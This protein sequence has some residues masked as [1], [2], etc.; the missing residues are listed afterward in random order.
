MVKEMHE[1]FESMNQA[2][3]EADIQNNIAYELRQEALRAQFQATSAAESATLIAEMMT[4]CTDPQ[5]FRQLAATSRQ[6]LRKTIETTLIAEDAVRRANE[7]DH[8]VT[9]AFAKCRECAD[10]LSLT[11]D[12]L[13]LPNSLERWLVS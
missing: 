8:K 2:R 4:K 7:V 6:A 5:V 13:E 3:L 12:R 9:E 10:R 1:L 11:L